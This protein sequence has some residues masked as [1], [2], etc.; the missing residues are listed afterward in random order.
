MGKLNK[1]KKKSVVVDNDLVE[2]ISED[3]IDVVENIHPEDMDEIKMY[4]VK[5]NYVEDNDIVVTLHGFAKRVYFDLPFGEL[6]YI[7]N[8]KLSYKNKFLTIYYI[9]NI[10]DAF[11]VNI[12]PI[13][14]LEDIGNRI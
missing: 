6:D 4:K 1:N 14:T 11:S 8:H 12:L 3:N 9:G 7:R 13:K 10:L 2:I 5:I